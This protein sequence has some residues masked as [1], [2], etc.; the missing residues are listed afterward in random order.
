MDNNTILET[1]Q[2]RIRYLFRD[3]D[4]L[5]IALTHSSGADTPL[6]SNE[7]MEFLGDAILGYTVC[8]TVYRDFP[9]MHE[10]DLTKIKSAVVSRATCNQIAKRLRLDEFLILGRGLGRGG[11]LPASILA[12]TMEALIAA[13]YL[14]GGI[15]AAQAFIL[16]QFGTEIEKM[17]EDCDADNYKSLLQQTS[18]RE[19]GASPEYGIVETGGP[20]HNRCFKVRVRIDKRDFPPAWGNNKK[21]AEQRA[22][23]NALAILGG[24]EPPYG[25]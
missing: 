8:E 7:R 3:T 6:M 24:D 14:D 1:C 4:L 16:E 13:I 22:A 15:V 25:E 5:R 18:Q 21:E 2:Q 10:G 20:D 9:H 23:E 11:R 12:N 19:F 17:G